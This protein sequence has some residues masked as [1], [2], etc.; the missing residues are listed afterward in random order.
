MQYLYMYIFRNRGLIFRKTCNMYPLFHLQDYCYRSYVQ[1]YFT[2]TLLI[3]FW[4]T[5]LHFFQLLMQ[6][7]AFYIYVVKLNIYV[8]IC[9]YSS[10]CGPGSSVGIAIDYGL[11]GPGSNT[12]EDEIFRPSRPTL[13]PTQPSSPGVMCGRGLL[14]T[15]HPFLVPQSWKSRAIPLPTL[16]ATP[17]LQ[18]DHFTFFYTVIFRFK[19][20]YICI[21]SNT[22]YC[23]F[24]NTLL[25]WTRVYNAFRHVLYPTLTCYNCLPEDDPSGLKHVHIEVNNGIKFN[26]VALCWSKIDNIICCKVSL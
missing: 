3:T 20:N 2:L 26:R 6:Q 4:G 21:S 8:F 17:G 23:N 15:T 13:G 7:L 18:R 24:S 12:G 1:Q 10:I 19:K 11:D 9:L 22:F 16:W 14:L 25:W 5:V